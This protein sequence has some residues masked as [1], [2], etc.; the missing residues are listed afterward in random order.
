MRD[1]LNK[2]YESKPRNECSRRVSQQ[3]RA[4]ELL[5]SD[6]DAVRGLRQGQNRRPCPRCQRDWAVERAATGADVPSLRPYPRS[7]S[8]HT[9]QLLV[10][11]LHG[12][13]Q[14][15]DSRATPHRTHHNQAGP[16]AFGGIA[17]RS[18]R[19]AAATGRTAAIRRIR[20]TLR[21]LILTR[22][23]TVAYIDAMIYADLLRAVEERTKANQRI[24]SESRRIGQEL[25]KRRELAGLSLR[26]VSRRMG[27]TAPYLSDLE[28]GR[29]TWTAIRLNQFV[30]AIR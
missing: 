7:I 3:D 10:Q 26:E 4:S 22:K 27:I 6:T 11:P 13:N 1:S 12:Q 2:T 14:S 25:R 30:R 18:R 29:R 17:E 5:Q 19:A 28:L 15:M 20:C 21:Y 23:R 16:G 9:I 24:A 8:G